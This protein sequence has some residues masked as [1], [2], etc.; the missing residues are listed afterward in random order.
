MF[1][2]VPNLQIEIQPSTVLQKV[3]PIDHCSIDLSNSTIGRVIGKSLI[4]L[5]NGCPP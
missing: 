3:H 2:P 4:D 1:G 5:N